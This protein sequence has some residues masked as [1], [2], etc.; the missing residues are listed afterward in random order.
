MP[1]ALPSL[2][3]S[4][5]A[6][7]SSEIMSAYSKVLSAEHAA[8]GDEDATINARVAGFFLICL[9]EFR[10]ILGNRAASYL[11]LE[12]NSASSDKDLREISIRYREYLLRSC[13]QLCPLYRYCSHMPSPM[14]RAY[15]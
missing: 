10:E 1:E 7:A 14:H 3:G 12:I 15:S 13:K 9:Y 8:A 11:S 4:A 2:E 6:H 5:I